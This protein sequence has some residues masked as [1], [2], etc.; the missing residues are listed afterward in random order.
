[1]TI[2]FFTFDSEIWSQPFIFGLPFGFVMFCFLMGSFN[3]EVRES[4]A[5][6]DLINR[7]V[8][9]KLFSIIESKGVELVTI[10]D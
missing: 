3:P 8:S 10:L 5:E 6:E 9:G 7:G 1:M 4:V 2:A